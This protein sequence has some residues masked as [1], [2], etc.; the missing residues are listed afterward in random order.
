M[1]MKWLLSV[2]LLA[3]V[4]AAGYVTVDRHFHLAG[5]RN[6]EL[7]LSLP[8]ARESSVT[9]AYPF[10]RI[11]ER[12]KAAGITTLMVGGT[13]LKELVE[14]G[15]TG[16]PK[17]YPVLIAVEQVPDGALV[18]LRAN[19]GLAAWLR[20]RL[21]MRLSPARIT[22]REPAPAT[23]QWQV[24]GIT[25]AELLELNL[26]VHPSDLAL[27]E[28]HG[29]KVAVHYSEQ[30]GWFDAGALFAGLP[31]G[32]PL[33][34]TGT[35]DLPQAGVIHG[36]MAQRGDVLLIDHSKP[37]FSEGMIPQVG[38]VARG[39][40]YRAAKVFRVNFGH[41]LSDVMTAVKDRHMRFVLVQP[42]HITGNLEQ[43]LADQTATWGR[44]RAEL[45][46]AGFA[47]DR[48]QPMQDYAP[49]FWAMV[50][51]ALA[52]GAAAGLLVDDARVGLGLMGA[53]GL[54]MAQPSLGL[55]VLALAA[56]VLLPAL[57]AVRAFAGNNMIQGLSWLAGSAFAGGLF[58]TALLGDIRHV[59]EL[60]LFRGIKLALVG[61]A[62]L[63]L[64]AL[65]WQHR[66]QAREWVRGPVR[67]WHVGL[68]VLLAAALALMLVRSGQE[69]T[70]ALVSE[71][72]LQVR[73][74][75]EQVMVARP[76]FKEFLVGWPLLVVAFWAFRRGLRPLG[77]LLSAA[78]L[79]APASLINSFAHLHTP[80]WL[81]LLRGFHGLWI[82]VLL[83]GIAVWVLERGLARRA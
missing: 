55:K 59:L 74:W 24:K 22:E 70:V 57:G 26:G 20:E 27:A 71:F 61:P 77:Y 14:H 34:W 33:L 37:P 21:T 39:V 17:E 80:V 78:G 83:G 48:V 36:R 56:A 25:P 28:R 29:L 6:V 16:F 15:A 45:Q 67:M 2:M 1:N 47:L 7:A 73:A 12:Y 30:P 68:A 51:V 40:G 60:E 32:T 23:Y 54:A 5:N 38:E 82:G 53:F 41:T 43:D 63:Y 19:S 72:E 49:P 81:S 66:G 44:L 31:P 65:A 18:T 62:L 69:A 76:R 75:L 13:T 35:G 11:L 10:D 46:Q 64:T 8:A 52:L 9:Q 3:G 42:Y 58:V 50:V 79:M 4:L